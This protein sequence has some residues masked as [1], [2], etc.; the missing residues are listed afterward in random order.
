VR[1]GVHPEEEENTDRWARRVSEAEGEERTPSGFC[2][3]VSWAESRPGPV[4]FPCLLHHFF[5]VQLFSFFV[6]CFISY[7]FQI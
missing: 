7:L 4:R 6:F 2:M 5:L 3:A 1:E